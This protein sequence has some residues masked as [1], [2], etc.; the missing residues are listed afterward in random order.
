MQDVPEA[1]RPLLA[2]ASGGFL[3]AL[4]VTP[5]TKSFKLLTLLA[6]LNADRFPGSISVEDLVARVGR[7][8]T[9]SAVLK[10]ELGVSLGSP[11]ELRRLIESNPIQA[12]SEGRGTEGGPYFRYG[13]QTFATTFEVPDALRS[14]FQELVR[15]LT[16]WRLAEYLRRP[17]L[18]GA[19]AQFVG[20]VRHSGGQPIIFLPD[21][22]RTP[23]VPTGWTTALADDQ[24]LELNFV[25]IAVNV[26]R[27]PDSDRNALPELLRQWF[28][29]DAGLL[30]TNFEVLFRHEGEHWVVSPLGG[31]VAATKGRQVWRHYLREEIPPLF[32]LA[33]N[34]ATWNAGFVKQPGHLFL[35]VTLD[36]QDMSR[37][38]R[39]EDRFIAP[40]VFQWQSQNRTT[41]RGAHGQ[42]L[43]LH[44]E[45]GLDVHLFV[46]RNKKID[47]KAAPF[48]YCGEVD[49]LNWEN[50]APITIRWKLLDPVP[51]T[52]RSALGVPH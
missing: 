43:R 36:K 15:E 37:D 22:A 18:V 51:E 42:D 13:G 11:G 1:H 45:R 46:R 50:E 9:R 39:Y 24:P 16:D 14:A 32:G 34:T 40:D 31:A 26:A 30:G 44:H 25:K 3:D 17:Q 21:R 27:L 33:F 48:V 41:Q 20:R 47:G 23:A 19:D 49:F 8:S 4:E 10:S 28:G 2:G 5:L 6:M 12:W 7:L 35:L 38:F 52:L 29:P